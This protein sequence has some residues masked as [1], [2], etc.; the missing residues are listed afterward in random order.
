MCAAHCRS[1]KIT[2]F[3][4]CSYLSADLLAFTCLAFIFTYTVVRY[5]THQSWSFVIPLQRVNTAHGREGVCR[6][7][8][9]AEVQ[10]KKGKLTIIA[11]SR[12]D[13]LVHIRLFPS[14]VRL[15]SCVIWMILRGVHTWENLLKHEKTTHY[16]G[17]CQYAFSCTR[18]EH[19][20]VGNEDRR[21]ASLL[22]E[23]GGERSSLF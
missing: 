8:I 17:G 9:A 12:F 13:M 14:F 3:T 7:R 2:I 20:C 15:L 5:K 6:E 23:T 1:R 16:F 11:V 4:H 10:R 18:V 22:C 19:I 21:M